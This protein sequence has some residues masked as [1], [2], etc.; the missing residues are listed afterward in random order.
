M[1]ILRQLLAS[2]YG[3]L[4]ALLVLCLFFSWVTYAEQQPIGVEAAERLLEQVDEKFPQKGS[5][6]VLGRVTNDSKTCCEMMGAGLKERG[7][8]VRAVANGGPPQAGRSIRKACDANGT[9]SLVTCESSFVELPLFDALREDLPAFAKTQVISPESYD[10]PNFLKAENLLNVANQIAVI[11]IL[12]IGM[13]M[14]IITAGIDLSVG[15]LIAFSAVLATW[16]IREMAGGADAASMGMLAC[17]VCA[18][19]ACGLFGVFTGGVVTFFGVPPFVAT[20]GMMLVGSGFAYMI[21]DGL[22]IY[23]LPNNFDWLGRGADL[24]GIPNAVIL[25]LLLY[26]GAHVLMERTSFGRHVYAVG[27]NPEAA[28]LSGVPVKRVLLCVYCGCGALA[29]LGGVVMASQFLSGDPKYGLMY[30]LYVIAA[31]VVGGTSLSGGQGKIFGTLIGAFI[32]AVIQNGMNLTGVESYTQK[33]V[34]GLVLLGAVLL[35]MLK[36]R[37]LKT[38]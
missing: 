10:W 32:I 13:T 27:G 38:A 9:L 34:L 21:S 12:A 8:E 17:C 2:D 29:G 20:L 7:W 14:V 19:A 4:G 22:S 26:V 23:Q 37:G 15:S 33:V 16:L 24:F 1:K 36:K 35:D 3:M 28:R 11:A 18:V 6:V 25:M 30:E 31:V 5:V